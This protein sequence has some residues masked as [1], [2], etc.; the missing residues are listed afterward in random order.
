MML[1]QAPNCILMWIKLL[2][3]INVVPQLGLLVKVEPSL[4]P[5]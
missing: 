1:L 2:K 3:F 5:Y 4:L